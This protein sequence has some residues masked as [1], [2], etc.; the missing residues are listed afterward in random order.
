MNYKKYLKQFGV[1]VGI[2]WIGML[3]SVLLNE[4]LNQP[5]GYATPSVKNTFKNS[6]AS[7][8]GTVGMLFILE[9]GELDVDGIF[10]K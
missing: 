6:V 2:S 4:I 1:G 7:G 9:Q 8:V 10:P 5:L 3:V